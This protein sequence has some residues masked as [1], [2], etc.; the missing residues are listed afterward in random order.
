M[1]V[2][3]IWSGHGLVALHAAGDLEVEAGQLAVGRRP[4]VLVVALPGLGGAQPGQEVADRGL[5]L[6]SGQGLV[7]G[8]LEAEALGCR[9][10]RR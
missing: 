7:A 10:P 6:G 8:H 5:R 2:S 9:A 4:L 3:S 1:T